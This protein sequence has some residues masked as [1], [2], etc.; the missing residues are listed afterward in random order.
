MNTNEI[1]SIVVVKISLSFCSNS[2]M[3]GLGA[4]SDVKSLN[5]E[6]MDTSNIFGEV[7]RKFENEKLIYFVSSLG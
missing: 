5:S 7:L 3:K 4:P 1:K 6:S 2:I